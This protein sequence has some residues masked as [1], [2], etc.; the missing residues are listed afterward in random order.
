[1]DPIIVN[2]G[3]VATLVAWVL[4]SALPAIL[5]QYRADV[6]ELHERHQKIVSEIV[7]EFRDENKTIA[8]RH[9][10]EL[11]KRDEVI[12]KIA[13]AVEGLTAEVRNG[14]KVPA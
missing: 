1:M 4:K 8:D 13:S 14:K 6:F 12:G 7:A 3:I 10:R 11:G 5:S 9:E 2:G